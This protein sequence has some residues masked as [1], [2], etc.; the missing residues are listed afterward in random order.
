LLVAVSGGLYLAGFKGST[1]TQKMELGEQV[2]LDFNSPALE[3]QVRQLISRVDE[4][5]RFEQIS[6]GSTSLQT[7]PTS[8]TYYVLTLKDNALELVNHKP[9]L[10]KTLI[11]LHKGHG[12]KLF[13]IYQQLVAAG[14]IFIMVSGVAT[15]LLNR[16]YRGKTSLMLA[17][18]SGVF[19][20]LALT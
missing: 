4:S 17:V 18:G 13:K 20:L 11:E 3:Q 7:R 6:A 12:P 16:R 8:R 5:Y 2:V 19:L 1:Q 9:N 15:G 10:Q 14:L